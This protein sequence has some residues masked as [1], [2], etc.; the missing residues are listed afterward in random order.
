MIS[1]FQTHI[2]EIFAILGSLYAAAR[3]LV[4]LTPTPKD[5]AALAKVWVGLRWLAKAFGLD[6]TQGISDKSKPPKAN[7]VLVFFLITT[8][9]MSGCVSNSPPPTPEAKLLIAQKSFA[10]IVRSLIVA[11]EAGEISKGDI[12]PITEIIVEG[13]NY[14]IRWEMK[15]KEGGVNPPGIVDPF[16]RLLEKL[17]AYQ[18][19]K[20]G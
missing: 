10:A 2:V 20:G 14:L 16:N 15:M 8:L 6:L 18:I 12:Q 1:W 19:G 5:D 17:V 11:L 13:Q 7:G 4:A 9:F 3:V